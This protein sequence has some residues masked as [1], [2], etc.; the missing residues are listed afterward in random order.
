MHL[1]GYV[2]RLQLVQQARGGTGKIANQL[3]FTIGNPH[4]RDRSAAQVVQ[5]QTHNRALVNK[6]Q[7][8]RV[9]DPATDTGRLPL[10]GHLRRYL[11]LCLS[12]L[13]LLLLL[14]RRRRRRGSGSDVCARRKRHRGGGQGGQDLRGYRAHDACRE[15]SIRGLSSHLSHT[16]LHKP[17]CDYITLVSPLRGLHDNCGCH[18]AARL[19]GRGDTHDR[20]CSRK[21]HDGAGGSGTVRHRCCWLRGCCGGNGTTAEACGTRRGRALH[22]EARSRARH[23]HNAC[24]TQHRRRCCNG[25]PMAGATAAGCHLAVCRHF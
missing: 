2:L 3:L 24:C 23:T 20:S 8:P 12:D 13:L 21:A 11:R 22:C 9:R 5:I 18:R 17:V 6:L 10:L 25:R 19:A 1:N 15:R 7:K 4:R 14:W 16:C